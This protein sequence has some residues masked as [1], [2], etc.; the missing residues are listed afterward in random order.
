MSYIAVV[1]SAVTPDKHSDFL[2]ISFFVALLD[3]DRMFLP[4]RPL[5]KIDKERKQLRS[6]DKPCA[7]SPS[8]M[9]DSMLPLPSAR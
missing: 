3:A 2:R 8:N 7:M 9:A 1:V 4:Y 5:Q 6:A